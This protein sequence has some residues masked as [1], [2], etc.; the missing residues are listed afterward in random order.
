LNKKSG[1]LGLS[2]VSS[3]CREIE[4]AAWNHKNERAQIALDKLYFRIKEALGSYLALLPG[5][6]AI[7]FTGGLGE[8]SPETREMVCK[9]LEHLGV[10]IDKEKN[11]FKG[12]E[13]E[14]SSP[15]SKIRVFVI[16]TNEELMI[17]RETIFVCKK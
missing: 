4:D 8:R 9:N 6:D 15:N 13:R 5:I 7:V 2:G 10:S 17:A 12:E 3:D 11:K 1:L 14:I 16:P